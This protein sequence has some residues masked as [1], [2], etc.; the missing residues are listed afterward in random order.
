MA[1]N[2]GDRLPL[3]TARPAMYSIHTMLITTHKLVIMFTTMVTVDIAPTHTA[4][5]D[6]AVAMADMA[7]TV[8]MPMVVLPGGSNRLVTN[9]INVLDES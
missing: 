8:G 9:M 4:R 7:G 2:H 5:A 1:I 6:M 3:Y